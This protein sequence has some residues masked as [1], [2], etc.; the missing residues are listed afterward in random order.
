M[1]M[2]MFVKSGV[3]RRDDGCNVTG[4]QDEH[5]SGG[6][7]LELGVVLENWPRTEQRH[8]VWLGCLDTCWHSRREVISPSSYVH[9][10]LALPG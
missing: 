3:A 5:G 10:A 7:A 4:P 1:V 9:R 6:N 8:L 2:R